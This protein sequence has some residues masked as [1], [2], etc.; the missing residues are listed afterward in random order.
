MYTGTFEPIYLKAIN[1]TEWFEKTATIARM[2]DD[3]K[4]W[5]S[6]ILS[7]MYK[8]IPFLS[9]HDVAINL[10]KIDPESGFGFGYAVVRNKVPTGLIPNKDE[11]AQMRI[12]IIVT[13]R[14]LQPFHVFTFSGNAYPLTEDRAAEV[15]SNPAMF[16]GAGKLPTKQ[17]SLIDQMYPPYQQ[18]QGFGRVTGSGGS[19]MA[20]GGGINKVASLKERLGRMGHHTADQAIKGLMLGGTKGLGESIYQESKGKQNYVKDP[21]PFMSPKEDKEKT[22]SYDFIKGAMAAVNIRKIGPASMMLQKITNKKS[23]KFPPGKSPMNYTLFEVSGS[24]F[25]VAISNKKAKEV[26]KNKQSAMMP[27]V[28]AEMKAMRSGA[29]PP[30]DFILLR[31]DKKGVTYI[32]PKPSMMGKMANIDEAKKLMETEGLTAQE[33][34][35]KVYPEMN[36]AQI[37]AAASKLNAEIDHEGDKRPPETDESTEDSAGEFVTASVQKVAFGVQD[38]SK[39]HGIGA[40]IGAVYGLNKHLGLTRN[41]AE[42]DRLLYDLGKMDEKTYQ[43]RKMRRLGSGLVRT[44]IYSAGGA[45]AAE[46]LNQ[47]YD[48]AKSGVRGMTNAAAEGIKDTLKSDEF[49]QTMRDVGYETTSGATDKLREELGEAPGVPLKEQLEEIGE[50]VATGA[51]R[52]LNPFSGFFGGKKKTDIKTA[53]AK[54]SSQNIRPSQLEDVLKGNKSNPVLTNI[55]KSKGLIP[56]NN[57]KQ[58]KS[59]KGEK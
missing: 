47:G 39:R 54:S 29:I 38:L 9:P 57:G 46:L 51:R 31:K 41:Q 45:G 28:K 3:D 19:G 55:L 6:V 7:E 15:L 11:D 56:R 14:Y 36:D 4:R 2:P 24:K 48:A 13:E 27:L 12:P 10:D 18:R 59:S 34:L 33:A 8:Q 37:A 35:R 26:Q 40:G 30:M 43:D 58:T 17:K 53:S 23:M 49:K 44:G 52:G 5:P 50:S 32:K 22:A 42:N 1:T 25:F 21:L 16:S 20:G